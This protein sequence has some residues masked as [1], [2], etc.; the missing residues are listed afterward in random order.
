MMGTKDFTGA[1]YR[2]SGI[3]HALGVNF[4]QD[5]IIM[6]YSHS[7]VALSVGK[8]LSSEAEQG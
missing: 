1:D 5:A 2:E 3:F 4:T 7:T 6:P 8:G